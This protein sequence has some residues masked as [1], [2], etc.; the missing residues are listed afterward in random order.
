MPNDS[1]NIGLSAELKFRASVLD[2]VLCGNDTPSAIMKH[3]GL[4]EPLDGRAVRAL[5]NSGQFWADV[6]KAKLRVDERVIGWLKA[7]GLK[8][9]Q[10]MDG[11]TENADPRVAFQATKDALDRIG[12]SPAQKVAVSGLEA[13]EALVRELLPDGEKEKKSE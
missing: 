1:E 8:Y 6:E 4:S 5:L 10:K 12:T 7:R 13:Y 2:A 3:L 11:L 9:A